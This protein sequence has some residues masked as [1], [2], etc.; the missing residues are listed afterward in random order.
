MLCLAHYQKELVPF[1][2]STPSQAP[3]VETMTCQETPTAAL[4]HAYFDPNGRRRKLLRSFTGHQD[5]GHGEDLDG[6]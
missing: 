5:I 4:R 1:I 6:D 3:L 2:P